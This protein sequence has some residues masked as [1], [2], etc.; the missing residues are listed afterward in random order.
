MRYFQSVVLAIMLATAYGPLTQSLAQENATLHAFPGAQGFGAVAAG[1]RG[2]RVIKVTNLNPREALAAACAESGQFDDA[3]KW[4]EEAIRQAKSQ[5]RDDRLQDLERR[6]S[7][8]RS[9]RP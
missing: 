1:S 6:L 2:G 7:L 5:G 9:G 3:V 4:Q 8:Y